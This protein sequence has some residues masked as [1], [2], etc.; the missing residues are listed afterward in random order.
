MSAETLQN[1]IKFLGDEPMLS[2][3][4]GEDGWVNFH[5]DEFAEAFTLPEGMVMVVDAEGEQHPTPGEIFSATGYLTV[6]AEIAGGIRK[7]PNI[8]RVQR[9]PDGSISAL[10]VDG[11]M[12][13]RAPINGG[14]IRRVKRT[15]LQ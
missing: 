5:E 8:R 14:N 11:M 15:D 3:Y 6:W 2:V 10:Y 9:D 4:N 12:T 7:E 1:A 13:N